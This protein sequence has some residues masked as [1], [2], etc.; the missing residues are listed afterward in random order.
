MVIVLG[1]WTRTENFPGPCK[2]V[3]GGPRNQQLNGQLG[4]ASLQSIDYSGEKKKVVLAPIHDSP[5]FGGTTK[6]CKSS[7]C[8]VIQRSAKFLLNSASLHSMSTVPAYGE[9]KGLLGT[10]KYSD[11]NKIVFVS[12]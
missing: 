12:Y 4:I 7:F 6:P 3:F 9:G 2:Y 11:P 5:Q 1:S 8:R 10:L